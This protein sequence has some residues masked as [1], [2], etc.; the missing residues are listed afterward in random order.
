MRAF[1]RR[2]WARLTLAWNGPAL[3]DA[4]M[5]GTCALQDEL[6][7]S[8][9]ALKRVLENYKAL[10]T[11]SIYNS[12]KAEQ[13]RVE[14]ADLHRRHNAMKERAQKAEQQLSKRHYTS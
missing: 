14:L 11:T 10:E 4:L 2:L 6:F 13:H 1:L 8:K 7:A 5:A 3:L 12:D 9:Q